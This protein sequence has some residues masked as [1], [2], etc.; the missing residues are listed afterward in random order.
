MFLEVF[1]T[2]LIIIEGHFYI[3]LKSL[4]LR[5]RVFDF[6]AGDRNRLGRAADFVEADLSHPSVYCSSEDE[7]A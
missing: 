1:F 3:F 7:D 2:A 4:C 6:R 5:Q